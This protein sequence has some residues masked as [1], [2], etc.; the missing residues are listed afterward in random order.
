MT[1]TPKSRLAR[2]GLS[3]AVIAAAAGITL[4]VTTLLGVTFQGS[5]EAQ[6]E[7][8]RV[9][10]AL[11]TSN[12]ERLQICVEAVGLEA[13]AES[14]AKASLQQALADLQENN[15]RWDD[16]A[17]PSASPLVEIGCPSPPSVYRDGVRLE[18]AGGKGLLVD[19]PVVVEEPSVY[20]AFVF[21][22]PPAKFDSLFGDAEPY[23]SEEFL[24]SG[25]TAVE[26]T[27]GLYLKSDALDDLPSLVDKLGRAI[28]VWEPRF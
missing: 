1:L 13:A 3:L 27:S 2:A 18:R 24:K 22:L 15:P 28:G 6:Q 8:R 10:S 9:A 16:A 21:V 11:L 23:V 7:V 5:G 20:R 26:V 12:R 25:H 19:P 4:G 14:Q 17:V